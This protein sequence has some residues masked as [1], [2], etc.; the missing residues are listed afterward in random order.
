MQRS[1]LLAQG[2]RISRCHT[3]NKAFKT[4]APVNVVWD[5]LRC[6]A[7]KNPPKRK[8]DNANSAANRI[9]SVPP[10]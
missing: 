8:D 6:W 2:Y 5:V 4:D 10:A 3:S 9:L 1:A 7:Q